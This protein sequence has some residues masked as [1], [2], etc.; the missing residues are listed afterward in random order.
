MFDKE[1]CAVKYFG[2]LNIM[3]WLTR[4]PS[5]AT[6]ERWRSTAHSLDASSLNSRVEIITE[7][8]SPSWGSPSVHTALHLAHTAD[9]KLVFLS[10]VSSLWVPLLFS[11][12]ALWCLFF[13]LCHLFP[14]ISFPIYT[15]RKTTPALVT[16]PPKVAPDNS[17]DVS[18]FRL[19]RSSIW[20]PVHKYGFLRLSHHAVLLLTHSL[21]QPPS[22]KT[23]I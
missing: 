2:A 1:A 7:R 18:D 5:R 14:T 3:S 13:L 4:G 20:L 12:S 6:D 22:P 17:L 9:I 16:A 21:A 8:F 19:S 11:V 23:R 15:L 10:I